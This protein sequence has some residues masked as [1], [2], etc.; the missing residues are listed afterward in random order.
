MSSSCRRNNKYEDLFESVKSGFYSGIVNGLVRN[1]DKVINPLKSSTET[2]VGMFQ[3]LVK[4]INLRAEH[5][6]LN[7][8]FADTTTK[9]KFLKEVNL[10]NDIAETMNWLKNNP[11][12]MN[13]LKLDHAGISAAGKL[14]GNI[15]KSVIK[16]L[17]YFSAFYNGY[18]AIN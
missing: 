4:G 16:A 2:V 7:T 10:G 18:E 6:N 17:P 8:K 1:C 15:G 3:V 9:L 11:I 5:I 13:R 14:V 12:A